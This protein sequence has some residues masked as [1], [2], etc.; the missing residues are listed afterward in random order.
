[1][2]GRT[3]FQDLIV[4]TDIGDFAFAPTNPSKVL[5]NKMPLNIT[6]LGAETYGDFCKYGYL[7]VLTPVQT[8]KQKQF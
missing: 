3:L 1:M 6:N 4:M 2:Y 5:A 8:N 7:C